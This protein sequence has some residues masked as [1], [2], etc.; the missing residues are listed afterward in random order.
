M[1]VTCKKVKIKKST[2]KKSKEKS[3]K[4][5]II[6]EKKSRLKIINDFPPI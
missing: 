4:F 3:H 5:I 6:I 2:K 1:G